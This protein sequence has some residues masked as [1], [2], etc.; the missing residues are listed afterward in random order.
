MEKMK[1]SPSKPDRSVRPQTRRIFTLF[2]KGMKPK[3]IADHLGVRIQIVYNAAHRARKKGMD[4]KPINNEQLASNR[5]FGYVTDVEKHLR[6]VARIIETTK[7]VRETIQPVQAEPTE[8]LSPMLTELS[9][10][11]QEVNALR[12]QLRDAEAVIRYLERKNED[13]EL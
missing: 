3:E 13:T 8:N 10:L 1:T 7:P 9:D 6:D 12:R 2:R 5:K 11:N 4:L